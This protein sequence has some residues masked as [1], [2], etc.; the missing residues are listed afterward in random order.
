MLQV[1]PR[2]AGAATHTTATRREIQVAV[3]RVPA[4]SPGRPVG[5]P[6]PP[7]GSRHASRLRVGPGAPT[8][9]LTTA[10]G[11]GMF[12]DAKAFSSFSVDDVS[13]AKTF[14]GQILGLDVSEK[15]MTEDVS[16]LTLRLGGGGRV[17]VYSKPNHTPASFTVLNFPVESVEK[18]LAALVERG[19]RPESIGRAPSAP[20]RRESPG[21]MGRQSPGSRTRPA[22]SSRWSKGRPWAER[23]RTRLGLTRP[24]GDPRSRRSRGP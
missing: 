4:R 1:C 17:L 13:R 22:T 2:D 18:A 24:T 11:E 12:K 21:V 10:R 16:M 8:F 20:T 7:R 14:Y 6:G 23:R 9:L 19:V 3:G 5:P 15:K